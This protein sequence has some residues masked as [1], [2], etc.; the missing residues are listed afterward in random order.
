MTHIFIAS[1]LRARLLAYAERLGAPARTRLRAAELM[2][3]PHGTLPHDDHF[4][5]RIACPAH[6]SGCVENPAP[7]L[8][9]HAH[10][11]ALSRGA[12][13]ASPALGA[14]APRDDEAP[15]RALVTAAPKRAAPSPAPAREP[16]RTPTA[17]PADPPASDAPPASI[18]VPLDDVDG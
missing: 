17:P 16:E 11:H 8:L 10:I 9:A 6:M 7:R 13:H 5:V 2:Q 14:R 3:Q 4:H 15:Y 18:A 1:P 12:P